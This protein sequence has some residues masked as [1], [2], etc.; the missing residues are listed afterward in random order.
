MFN[1]Q[2][3]ARR[4][5][6]RTLYI[7]HYDVGYFRHNNFL[8]Q[9]VFFKF[10]RNKNNHMPP[11]PARPFLYNSRGEG[12]VIEKVTSDAAFDFFGRVFFIENDLF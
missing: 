6:D 5:I 4:R 10:T 7:F 1:P 8:S 3:V 9:V 12:V 2:A 11:F